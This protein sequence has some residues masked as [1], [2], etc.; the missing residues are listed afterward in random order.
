MKNPETIVILD[1]GS[2]YSQLIAR[3]IRELNIYSKI[4]PFFATIEEIKEENPSGIILSGG[5]ASV[6]DPNSPSCDP[7]IFNLN[8]PILGIC[9]GLQL[10]VKMLG[11]K[12]TK[13]PSREYGRT[14]L[15]ID[16]NNPLFSGIIQDKFNVWMSH[17]D[18]VD[19][20]PESFR[21]IA[22]TSNTQFA[23][24]ICPDKNYYGVQFHP[25]V[26]HSE[27]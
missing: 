26:A 2:Q 7:R 24:V 25:E 6:T 19:K 4:L 14:D 10:M 27:N 11:G 5:P 18:K 9:Y 15:N 3:R 8:S 23:A 13:S 17:G 16:N 1:F 22:A 20:L 21:T 12:V